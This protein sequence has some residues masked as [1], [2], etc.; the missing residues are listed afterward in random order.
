MTSTEPLE[1]SQPIK[2]KLR[3]RIVKDVVTENKD[4]MEDSLNDRSFDRTSSLIE[5][6]KSSGNG[7]K[8]SLVRKP[9]IS[10]L[11]SVQTYIYNNIRENI[12]VD[13]IRD[14]WDKYQKQSI[15]S[16]LIKIHS[17]DYEVFRDIAITILDSITPYQISI[18][19]VAGYRFAEGPRLSNHDLVDFQL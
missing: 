11:L 10:P 2:F 14:L 5:E 6:P 7:I 16:S 1:G 8:L 18:N 17:I 15:H 4:L 3:K 9:T 19:S 13:N 12:S